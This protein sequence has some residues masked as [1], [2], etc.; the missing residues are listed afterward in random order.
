MCVLE[1]PASSFPRYTLPTWTGSGLCSLR[2]QS[3]QSVS[4]AS[5]ALDSTLK[6]TC[7]LHVGVLFSGMYVVAL[8]CG[9]EKMSES[10][11]PELYTVV[12]QRVGTRKGAWV[13]CKKS[14]CANCQAISP[15]SARTFLYLRTSRQR[16]LL[17]KADSLLTFA[18]RRFLWLFLFL[19]LLSPSSPSSSSSFIDSST[20]ITFRSIRNS[21]KS[22]FCENPS[23]SAVH[24]TAFHV[25]AP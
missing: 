20:S 15:A 18:D 5:T 22:Y 13:L 10:F 9:G 25:K 16:L 3:P 12:S 17:T 7:S 14:R 24:S 21:F 4:S 2:V 23:C 8:C 11:E 1:V 6:K 19:P